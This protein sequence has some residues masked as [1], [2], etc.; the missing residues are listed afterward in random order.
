MTDPSPSPRRVRAALTQ[1]INAYPDMP[2]RVEQLPTLRG[3]LD[4]IRNANVAHHIG[5]MEEAAR[6]GA[7]II[8]FGELFTGPYFALTHDPMWLDLAESAADG[9]TVRALGEAARRLAM[10]VVAPIYEHDAA[11]GKRF[12][13]AVLIDENG[14]VIGKFRKS[15]IPH[16]ANEKGS[17]LEGFYYDRSDGANGAWPADVSGDPFFP[18]F[19]TSV[20][21][22][23][24]AICYDRHFAGVMWSL[25]RGGAELVFSPAVTFGEKSERMWQMEFDVDAARH[26]IFIGGS[27]RCGSETP[28][29]QPFFGQSLFVGPNGRLG[30]VSSHPELI[31]ADIDLATLAR[32]DPSGWNLQRD[33]R[34]DVVMRT[35]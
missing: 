26:N 21:N 2:E 27:N 16:G 8:C 11:T 31:I 24:V 1:T 29:N 19:K 15:H 33:C 22:V 4:D 18:V 35:P 7:R 20:G 17:F 13:T 28:W 23:G 12:N 9:A 5:L 3:R 10:I 14:S 6:Q 25:A 30:N 34:H 32:P